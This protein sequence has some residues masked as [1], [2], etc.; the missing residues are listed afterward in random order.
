MYQSLLEFGESASNPVLAIIPQADKFIPGQK[1]P[2]ARLCYPG[3]GLRA[4]YHQHTTP[5]IRDGEHGHFHIFLTDEPVKNRNSWRHLAALS[6]DGMGQPQSW[7]CVNNWVTGGKWLSAI[8]AE[9]YLPELFQQKTEH[10]AP[11]E[12]W[13]FHMLA[14]YF[15]RL[16]ELLETR[17]RRIGSLTT[18]VSLEKLFNDR[19]VYQ[20]S[21]SP[22]DLLAD[23]TR[24]APG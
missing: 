15:S 16:L 10:L 21:E 24:M 18:S 6:V 8:Q 13:I 4:Y 7:I 22:I 11:V 23:L 3:I 5:Y 9:S 20:L 12:R 17:D 2:A 19:L 14:V 1:Y